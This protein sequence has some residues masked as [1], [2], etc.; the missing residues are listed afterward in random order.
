M[1][2]KNHAIKRISNSIAKIETNYNCT[3]GYLLIGDVV[4][5]IVVF[6]QSIRKLICFTLQR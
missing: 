6:T 3:D 4:S 2:R 1:N 5:F